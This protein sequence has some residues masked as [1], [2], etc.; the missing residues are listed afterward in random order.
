MPLDMFKPENAKRA[1]EKIFSSKNVNAAGNEYE[2]S[3]QELTMMTK[4]QCK[5]MQKEMKATAKKEAQRDAQMEI[6]A[7]YSKPLDPN[8][9]IDTTE[10]VP[11][12]YCKEDPREM[13]WELLLCYFC[14]SGA[15]HCCCADPPYSGIPDAPF[16][17]PQ[18]VEKAMA[19]HKDEYQQIVDQKIS[20]MEM[21]WKFKEE[22]LERRKD[23]W[24]AK[25]RQRDDKQLNDG[26][27]KAE[28]KISRIR[29]L[30][31]QSQVTADTKSLSSKQR[32]K[33]QRGIRS[34]ECKHLDPVIQMLQDLILQTGESECHEEKELAVDQPNEPDRSIYDG[35]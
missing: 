2:R 17:C 31:N 26:L 28:H 5:R 32:V 3:A 8:I 19:E 35:K 4:D 27:K 22:A 33:L 21:R 12:F 14:E 7:K 34:V 18:C 9:V 1:F 25:R 13:E 24:I 20:A 11:C 10:S 29:D 16:G 23:D 30:I 15:L 6:C